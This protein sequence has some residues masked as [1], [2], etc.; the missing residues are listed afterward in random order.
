MEVFTKDC[1]RDQSQWWRKGGS[2]GAKH[3][4]ALEPVQ[5]IASGDGGPYAMQKVLGWCIAGPIAWINPR[6]K[7]KWRDSSN[8]EEN[9]WRIIY[10]TTNEVQQH[11]LWNTGKNITLWSTVFEVDWP[12]NNQ[13]T[14]SLYSTFTVKIKRRQSSLQ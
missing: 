13:V 12:G 8:A 11:Y 9:L 6:N 10:R 2:I 14:W 4:R 7:T 5:V 1:W 3:T